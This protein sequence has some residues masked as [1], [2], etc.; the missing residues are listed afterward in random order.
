MPPTTLQQILAKQSKTSA[1][2][3]S[4]SNNSALQAILAKGKTTPAQPQPTQQPQ[5]SLASKFFGF[6]ANSSPVQTN[7]PPLTD[8]KLD[9]KNLGNAALGALPTAGA[10][11]GGFAGAAGGAA[12][13]SE[14]GPGAVVPAYAG[15]VAGAAAGAALGTA[16]QEGIGKM[17]GQGQGVSPAAVGK[18]ALEF[19]TLEAVGGPLLSVAGKGLEAVGKGLSKL[20]FPLSS[21][22]AS[23]VQAYK[24]G[25]TF[26]D[27]IGG[28]ITGKAAK[29]PVTSGET[30]F[31]KGLVGTESMIGV[32]AKRAANSLW[33][34]LISPSL[35]AS[36]T[37]VDMPSFF[38]EAESKI[39]KDNPEVARQNQL[40]EALDSF[41]EDYSKTKTATLDQLQ[42][43]KEG[44]AKFIPEKAY[45]GKP[46]GGAAND[47]KDTLADIARQKIYGALGP[48]VKQAYFDHGNLQSLQELGQQAMT[49]G[50]LKG[51]FGN[52]WSGVKDM[53]LTPVATIGGQSVYKVGEVGEFL[54]RP[55]ARMLRDL[56]AIPT[57]S[58]D[59]Q[60]SPQTTPNQPQ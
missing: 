13:G 49:G 12:L 56:F 10:I 41:K 23:R 28:L 44:W 7:T 26:F 1:P 9:A 38:K 39:V 47:V 60:P 27:R 59:Q 14:T 2:T 42:K 4:S 45:K 40:L 55:G 22:E 57:T 50:K 17:F 52:F 24:A 31:N 43:F 25:T 6:G 3:D 18:N 34:K 21:L 36:K 33:N 32:Q 46:I 30:A 51:G 16:A 37:I 8:L 58:G 48:E 54:G 19:G 20:P 11:A 15:G 53:A 35:K 5:Q 29:A